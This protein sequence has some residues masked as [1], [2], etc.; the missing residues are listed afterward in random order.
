[1]EA[2]RKDRR[3]KYRALR[4]YLIIAIAMMMG[5]VGW[6]LFLLPNEITTGGITGIASILYWG[7]DIPVSMVYFVLNAILLAFSLKILGWRFCAKTM[8]AVALFTLFSSFLQH[9][10]ADLHLLADQKFM[11]LIVGGAFIG[12]SIG[13]GLSCGGSTGGSDVIAAIVRKY[14]DIS[15]GHIILICDLCIITSSYLVLKDWEKVIYGY[16]L[17]FISSF[18]V[19][20]VVNAMRRSVQFFII[21]D[22]YE[23]IGTAINELVPRGCTIFDGHGFYSGKKIQA[24]F[25]IAKKSES[26]MIF[27]LIEDID[28]KAFVSQSSV[29]GVYGLGFDNF[30]RRNKGKL[31]EEKEMIS[32]ALKKEDLNKS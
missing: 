23:T 28:P 13:L 8:Y 15:L 31:A 7:F 30:R 32:G 20:Q 9:Y 22:E 27:H 12:T 3:A 17:L 1:M 6:V 14:K 10:T 24:L 29:I 16:V 26:S 11:A 25:V 19:D 5:S 4:D 2:T 18:C 21:S